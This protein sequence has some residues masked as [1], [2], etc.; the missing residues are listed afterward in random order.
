MRLTES[1][2]RL[3]QEEI[4]KPLDIW[5]SV[6]FSEYEG[7]WCVLCGAHNTGL[8]WILAGPYATKEEAEEAKNV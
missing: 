6:Q 2:L 7:G 8:S 5:A 3:L 1:Q 4:S